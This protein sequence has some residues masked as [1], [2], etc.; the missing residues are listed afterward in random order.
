MHDR[1]EK[2]LEIDSFAEAV[3]TDQNPLGR[4]AQL[5]DTGLPLRRR[6]LSGYSLDPHSLRKQLAQLACKVMDRRD[7]TTEQHRVELIGE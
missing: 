6:K 2:L 5:Q 1:V 7:E 3:R 4:P